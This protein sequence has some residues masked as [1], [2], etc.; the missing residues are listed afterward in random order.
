M[1]DKLIFFYTFDPTTIYNIFDDDMNLSMLKQSILSI[2]NAKIEGII[3]DYIFV[4]TSQPVVMKTLLHDLIKCDLRI[5]VMQCHVELFNTTTFDCF[6]TI[7]H[8]RFQIAK[9]IALRNSQNL[10]KSAIIYLD[11][12]TYIYNAHGLVE[13][14]KHSNM[15][16][17]I[18]DPYTVKMWCTD[19]QLVDYVNKNYKLKSDAH[20]I[21]SG[22]IYIPPTAEALN[23]LDDAIEIYDTLNKK[24][25]NFFGLDQ[26]VLTIILSK[27][28]CRS[29]DQLIH[30]Q[31]PLVHYYQEKRYHFDKVSQLIELIKIY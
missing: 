8:M 30:D 29:I 3:I 4:Y 19:T 18:N 14:L 21:N 27:Y 11:N 26:L 5:K 1:T 15:L 17:Y 7:G 9:W 22:I 2:I 16:G 12:D 13:L 6:P 28:H 23:D 10:V 31:L 24:G 25:F 20:L